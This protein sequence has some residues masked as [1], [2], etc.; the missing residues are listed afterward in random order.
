MSPGISSSRSSHWPLVAATMLNSASSGKKITSF[1]LILLKPL[2]GA[3]WD[4]VFYCRMPES[5][6]S[7][8]PHEFV[9]VP[10]LTRERCRW[11]STCV[12]AE[13]APG[14]WPP[15][16]EQM[17][18]APEQGPGQVLCSWMHSP[19][20]CVQ[21]TAGGREDILSHGVSLGFFLPD[22]LE[23]FLSSAGDKLIL[24]RLCSEELAILHLKCF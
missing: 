15:E 14:M 6:W 9:P 24:L 1:S 8:L 7:L 13:R 11:P 18:T 2:F 5:F 16:H 22:H 19:A 12:R 17:V 4:D 10:S 23:W 20:C 3:S 21:S